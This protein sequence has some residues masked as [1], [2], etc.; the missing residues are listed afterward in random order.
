M[1]NKTQ[2]KMYLK[3]QTLSGGTANK[4]ANL[5]SNKIKFANHLCS[6]SSIDGLD[7]FFKKDPNALQ[8]SINRK[9]QNNSSIIQQIDENPLE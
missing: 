1:L 5:K 2:Q 9:A 4:K 6:M 3:G 8:D 7:K